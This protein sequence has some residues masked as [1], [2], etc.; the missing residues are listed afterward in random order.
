V[1]VCSIGDLLLDV[2]VRLREPLA[3]GDDTVAETSMHPGGQ[4]ANVAAWT[5]ALGAGARFV[6]AV[7]DDDAAARGTAALRDLG[8]EV[9]A[10]ARPGATGVVVSLVEPGGSRTM[11]SDRGVAPEL[12]ADELDDEWFACDWLHVPAY[13]L[14]R[15]PL[16][17]A[18]E[19]AV[20]AARGRGA[21]LS[22]DLSSW[23]VLGG[24][25]RHR[26]TRLEPDVVFAT[27]GE[28][29]TYREVVPEAVIK[30]GPEGF[31]VVRGDDRRTH[32]AL[33]AAVIDSTGAGDALA[34]GYL[35]G[36]PELAAQAA[37]WC[38]AKAGA[39]P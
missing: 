23:S 3:H 8:V 39:M 10:C 21:R 7:G 15:E 32:A 30:Y 31:S 35:L 24:I 14:A 2:I 28:W 1:A 11:A 27:E 5:A 37:A 33:D 22:L 20:A 17:S 26:I 25:E 36:G 19:S 38:V 4:A 12:R 18:A 6:G 13:S 16:A 29:L 9:C 34:A